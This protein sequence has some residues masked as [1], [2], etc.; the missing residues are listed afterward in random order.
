MNRTTS[1]GYN[2]YQL[3]L[4]QSL[5]QLISIYLD[6]DNPDDFIPGFVR[7]LNGRQ[8]LL[9]AVTPRGKYDGHYAIRMSSI[10][11]VLGED[12]LAERLKLLLK[13]NRETPDED[14]PY[15]QG[16]DLIHALLRASVDRRKLVSVFVREGDYSGYV[17]RLDDMRMSY[18][19]IDCLGKPEEAIELVLRDIE[20]VSM[21]SEEDDM[22][23]KLYEY[24]L[25]SSNIDE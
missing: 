4:N 22:W 21:G 2:G 20:M 9:S 7:A 24:W 25:S 12:V 14:I 3:K 10:I 17:L 23:N 1:E 13:I 16:E 18:L 19:P 15:E 11:M 5:N 6:P 8:A